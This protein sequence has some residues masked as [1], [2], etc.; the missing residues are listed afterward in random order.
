MLTLCAPV[1][2]SIVY[3]QLFFPPLTFFL[4]DL[5]QIKKKQ[6]GDLICNSAFHIYNL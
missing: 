5:K 6:N 3:K 4:Q 2:L 1:A